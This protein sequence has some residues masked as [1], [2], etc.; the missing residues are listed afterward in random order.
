MV[1]EWLIFGSGRRLT[2]PRF[3]IGSW[4][5]GEASEEATALAGE[6][7]L[8]D[9]E[10]Q[11]EREAGEVGFGFGDGYDFRAGGKA[12]LAEGFFKGVSDETCS[13]TAIETD[14]S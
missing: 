13:A 12:G 14:L 8:V 6:A 2:L 11:E 7:E 9:A 4:E 5:E 1:A 3:S 10:A